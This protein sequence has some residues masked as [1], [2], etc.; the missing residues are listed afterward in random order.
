LRTPLF[1]PEYLSTAKKI[2]NG[3]VGRLFKWTK[4]RKWYLSDQWTAAVYSTILSARP[5][6]DWFSS[7]DAMVTGHLYNPEAVEAV[8]KEGKNGSSRHVP[9]LSRVINLELACRWTGRTVVE[10]PAS[11]LPSA[12]GRSALVQR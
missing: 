7:C 12:E 6:S 3:A 4:P 2:S 5:Y 10:A 8:L 1:F 9:T 11:T